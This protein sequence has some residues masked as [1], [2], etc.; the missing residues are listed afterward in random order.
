MIRVTT[1]ITQSQP[2]NTVKRHFLDESTL[3]LDKANQRLD[4]R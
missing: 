2:S 4:R 3:F 1:E